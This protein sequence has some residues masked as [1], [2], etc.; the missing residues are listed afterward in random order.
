MNAP[1]KYHGGKNGM[2]KQVIEQFP[3]KG[4]YDTYIE[5]FGGSFGVGFH[6]PEELIAPIEIYN[7]LEQNVYALFKVL[8]DEKKFLEFKKLC[9][10]SYYNEQ[11]RADFREQLKYNNGV[12]DVQ[13]AFMFF[14]VNRTSHNGIGGFSM[15]K[16][17]RRGMSKN[18]SDF[19]ATVDGLEK[20]H[21]RLSHLTVLNRDGIQLMK[22]NNSKNVFIYADPPYVLDTRGATRYTVDMDDN[23]QKEFLSVCIESKAKLLI[24]GYDCEMY[25]TLLDNGFTKTNFETNNRTET[26]WKNY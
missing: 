23:N 17:V 5:P 8:T 25:N 18:V 22:E 3:A 2:A 26:L 19:L 12:E 13:R 24:S 7:D 15:Q 1:I 10:C 6:I 4:S 9:D 11:M 21:Q 14:Y 16:I 20:V